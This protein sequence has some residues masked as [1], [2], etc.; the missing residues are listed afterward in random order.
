M[1][2]LEYCLHCLPTKTNLQADLLALLSFEYAVSVLQFSPLQV[3][4]SW[5]VLRI[6]VE[7][8]YPLEKMTRFCL[9]ETLL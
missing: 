2:L 6:S 1:A 8:N 3:L 5:Q 7:V 4:D 9:K